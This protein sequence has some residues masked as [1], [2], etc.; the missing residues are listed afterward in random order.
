[1][2]IFSIRNFLYFSLKSLFLAATLTIALPLQ[3]KSKV[4]LNTYKTEIK[5]TSHNKYFEH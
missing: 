1:M 5:L 4:Y 3:A 2:K